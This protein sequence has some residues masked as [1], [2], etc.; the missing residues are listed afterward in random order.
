[1]TGARPGAP[2]TKP[3]LAPARGG[4]PLLVPAAFLLGA[5]TAVAAIKTAS[6]LRG[7]APTAGGRAEAG[8]DSAALAPP[9]RAR[10]HAGAGANAGQALVDPRAREEAEFTDRARASA[11]AGLDPAFAAHLVPKLGRAVTY[12]MRTRQAQLLELRCEGRLCV[13]RVQLTAAAGNQPLRDPAVLAPEERGCRVDMK[14]PLAEQRASAGPRRVSFYYQC[15]DWVEPAFEA[16]EAVAA[17]SPGEEPTDEA[18]AE[19]TP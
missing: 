8:E 13:V 2:A 1:L 4:S 10:E 6:A 7:E 17:A 16:A 15:P 5:L 14:P 3:P 19:P 9:R 11:G 12:M 18:A